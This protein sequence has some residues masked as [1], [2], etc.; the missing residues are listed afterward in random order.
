MR[1]IISVVYN[2]DTLN[3]FIMMICKKIYNSDHIYD[4]QY[5][6]DDQQYY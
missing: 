6:P 3:T 5:D 4:R 1:V 2:I